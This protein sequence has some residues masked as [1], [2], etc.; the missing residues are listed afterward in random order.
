MSSPVLFPDVAI[1]DAALTVGLPAHITA[2]TGIDALVHA[3]EAFTSK[4]KKNPISDMLALR[5]LKLLS[6][7]IRI[8]LTSPEDRTAREAMLGIN[9]RGT[10][11]CQCARWRG[12]RTGLSRSTTT[13]RMGSVTH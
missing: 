6:E 2:M 12:A 8:V 9:V 11:I 3:I 10:G 1:L 4:I 13:Y 5:A 7:N